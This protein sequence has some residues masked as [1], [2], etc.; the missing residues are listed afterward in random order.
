[1]ASAFLPN[2]PKTVSAS[3][4][5]L[6]PTISDNYK[7]GNSMA[8]ATRYAIFCVLWAIATLFHMAQSRIYTSQLHYVLLTLAAIALILKPASVLRLLTFIALQLYEVL[9]TLP[10]ISNHWVFTTF[11]NLT[12]M[13]ALFYLVIKKGTFQIDR[14]DFIRLFAPV[15]RVELLLL[16]F[17]VVLHKLNWDFLA[18]ASS[19]AVLLYK[20]QHLEALLP[21]SSAL[22]VANIYLT[23]FIETL[24]PLLL[25]FRITRNAGLFIGLCF[26]C[27]IAFNSYNGF[28]DFSSMVFA[29]YFLFTDYKFSNNVA[30]IY[31]KNRSRWSKIKQQFAHF[32][33]LNVFVWVALFSSAL[34]ILKLVSKAFVDYSQGLWGAYSFLFILI[35]ILSLRKNNQPKSSPVFSVQSGAFLLFPVIV[36]LNGIS[37][38]LGLKTEYSFAMFSNLRTEGGITNHLFIPVSAQ[39]FGFQ[40]MVEIVSSSD[41]ELQKIADEN[42]LLTFFQFKNHVADHHPAYVRYV[43]NGQPHT[44]AL[45]TT[46]A[47]DELLHKS[48]PLLRKTMRFRL[49]NKVGSQPCQ[50]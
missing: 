35:F 1:M 17:F 42:K 28:Y 22:M 7:A 50:H 8:D 9:F 18:P 39:V 48:F 31:W 36:F 16:Y 26:H 21:A 3:S 44:F 20:A 46:P 11:V 10:N 19:C 49:I 34:L 15:V 37:P 41:P 38:Y 23:L 40:D 13:Q 30:S 29:I 32:S 24:I 43:R 5:S 33:I 14:V 25:F 45:A 12:I 2:L 27:V 4:K 47:N 6:S